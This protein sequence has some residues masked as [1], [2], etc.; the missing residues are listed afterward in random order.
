MG[1]AFGAKYPGW[2]TLRKIANGTKH[3][4]AKKD[5]TRKYPDISLAKASEVA[6]EDRDFWYA[7][8]GRKTL[9]IEVD[10]E[11]RSVHSLAY[12]FCRQFLEATAA[13]SERQP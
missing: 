4:H 6:W 10:G 8:Q 13:P 11:E 1:E 9:F 7:P 5:G 12:G 3:P 2:Q